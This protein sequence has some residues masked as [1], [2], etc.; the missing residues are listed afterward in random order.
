M[1]IFGILD[2]ATET[3]LRTKMQMNFQYPMSSL[4]LRKKVLSMDKYLT[5]RIG[6]L[7]LGH[8]VETGVSKEIISN[9]IHP[10]TCSLLSANPSP[11]P[12]VVKVRQ[13]S[14]QQVLS[15]E[16]EL[17]RWTRA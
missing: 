14:M 8:I 10:E 9:P 13:V 12:R 16:E 2:R 4:N 17:A 3:A 7:Q 11:N 15:T 6:V 1:D 5:D